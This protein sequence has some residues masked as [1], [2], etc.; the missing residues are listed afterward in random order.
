MS[1]QGGRGCVLRVAREPAPGRATR[2]H[3]EAQGIATL[4]ARDGPARLARRKG[5]GEKR[6]F[7]QG[8]A[9]FHRILPSS[10]FQFHAP[11]HSERPGE[12][13][14]GRGRT[15]WRALVL[16]IGAMPGLGLAAAATAEPETRLLRFPTTNGDAI[17][18]SHAGQLYTVGV[19]GGT[20]RRLTNTPGYA[21]FPRFSADGQQLAFSAQYDGNTEVYLMPAAGGEPKRLTYT[22]TLGRDDL[23]DR[24]G[25]NNLVMAWTQTTNEIVFRS[26][27]RSFNDFVGQLYAVTAAGDLPRQVPV[28]HGGFVSFSPD[29]RKMA[30]NR[31]FREFRTWKRYR[32]GMADEIWVFDFATGAL[33]NITQNEAQDIIPMWAPNGKIYFLS[34]R[35]GHLNLFSY[36]LRSKRTTQ[37]TR[38]TDF[39]VKF[40]SL[41]RGGIVFEQAGR[42]WFFDLKTEQARAVPIV[43]REDFAGARSGIVNVAKFVTG[44]RPS[45]D[46]KRAVVTARGEVFT[47][48]AKNGPTRNLSNTPGVH[49]RGAVWSPDGKWIAYVG[50]ATGENELYVR[51]QDG[52]EA[53]IQLTKGAD[54]YYFSPAWSPDS[55]KLMW[56]DRAQRLRI[57]DIETKEVTLV[58][59]SP[60]AEI[61]QYAWSPDS[62][63]VAWTRQER[64]TMSKVMLRSLTEKKT[65]AVTDGWYAANSPSFSD[66]GKFLFFASSRDFRPSYGETEWNHIYQ[67]MERVYFVALAKDTASPFA[68]KSD[69][70]EIA[71]EEG[72]DSKDPAKA[73]EHKEE[74]G[75]DK[76]DKS[77]VA[78]AAGEK[79]DKKAEKKA[80]AK[81]KVDWDGLSDRVVGLPIVPSNYGPIRAVGDKVF[82]QRRSGGYGPE[83]RRALAVYNLKEQKETELGAVE[84]FEVTGDGKKMLVKLGNDYG[85]IELPSAKVELK[86]ALSLANLEM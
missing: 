78:K 41:G 52:K 42:I 49:E 46:G 19:E 45:P 4:L 80:A 75:K 20:A 85:L 13:R 82:Y 16:V 47:V 50:D 76:A 17:V 9:M 15:L 77:A 62:Q 56:G 27:M 38:F 34:D 60:F 33:E 23:A 81:V 73:D 51:T 24:M 36:E 2:P 72:K 74:G 32:G 39:D 79:A 61:T 57:V 10:W 71:K 59:E 26:R 69:E 12:N 35:D 68:P 44:V 31:V 25:P 43:V 64:G 3:L 28:P 7:R 6:I 66:D 65:A 67:N 18:F 83:A 63:W 53:P 48:P 54:T 14:S 22:A 8:V 11:I 55:K 37:H 84:S 30:Y 1:C 5:T 70:V 21:V 58:E 40:P 86:E 29:D